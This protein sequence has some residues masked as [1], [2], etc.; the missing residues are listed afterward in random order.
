[1]LNLAID[2]DDID[3]KIAIP[4]WHT[5]SVNRDLGVGSA[6]V[7]GIEERAGD[8]HIASDATPQRHVAGDLPE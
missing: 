3:E 4:N 6:I 2:V 7:R 5:D 1:V 8:G